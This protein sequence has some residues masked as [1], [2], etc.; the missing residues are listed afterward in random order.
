MRKN[1]ISKMTTPVISLAL[2]AVFSGC[3]K[4]ETPAM[5]PPAVDVTPI[6]QQDVPVYAEAVGTLQANVNATISAQVGGYVISRNYEEGGM[7]T[8]GQVLFQI[9]DRTYKALLDQALA[10]LGKSEQDVKRYTPLAKTQAISEQELDDAIQA[11][12]ANEAAVES[13]RLNYD[14]CKVLSPADGVAGLAQ[15]QVGDLVGPGS[16]ALTTVQTVDP[17]RVYFSV[18]QQL[19][20]KL[21]EERLAEGKKI[22]S[23]EGTPLELTLA[24][25]QIYPLKGRVRY[26]DNQVD[27]RTGTIR[28]VGEFDNPN[29]LLVPG[30]FVRVRA[31]VGVTKDALLVPQ[32][33]VA[34]LQ[35]RNL[36]GIVGA[37]NKVSIRPV[38]TGERVGGLWVIQGNIKAGEKVVVEGIQKLR[39]DIEV[40]P[41]PFNPAD[42][43]APAAVAQ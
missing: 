41:V 14:F 39:Q 10:K 24:S 11:N 43:A 8:N 37:D 26:S 21:M 5:P 31:L 20:T 35:G 7:V 17:I 6:V 42:Q 22:D 34:D 23:P 33:A 4:E 13:A 28:V 19:L 15:A 30:M 3:E 2:L 1:L 38:I 9:D 27:V 12:L 18:S 40:N 36:I 25:G 32:Q 29:R 16:G